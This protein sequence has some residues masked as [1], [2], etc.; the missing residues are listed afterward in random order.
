MSDLICG[1]VSSYLGI[2]RS[3]CRTFLWGKGTEGV[4]GCKK[5]SEDVANDMVNEG[6]IGKIERLAMYGSEDE[7]FPAILALGTIAAKDRGKMPMIKRIALKGMAKQIIKDREALAGGKDSDAVKRAVM[8]E[9]MGDLVSICLLI[10]VETGKLP[11]E[12]DLSVKEMYKMAGEIVLKASREAQE[13]KDDEMISATAIILP[14]LLEKGDPAILLQYYIDTDLLSAIIVN[15]DTPALES[16]L[17]YVEM[18]INKNPELI[19]DQKVKQSL[20]PYLVKA[21]ERMPNE[22]FKAK[23]QAIIDKFN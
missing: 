9:V 18:V 6:N 11:K 2:N 23:T 7:K 4:V 22:N 16:M 8:R 17:D 21:K 19:S 14:Q 1:A 15:G 10:Q 3:T 12:L 13:K 5:T 20:V